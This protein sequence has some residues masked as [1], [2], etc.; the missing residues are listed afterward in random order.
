MIQ[1]TK[2][3]VGTVAVIIL[4]GFAGVGGAVYHESQVVSH[5]EQPVIVKTVVVVPTVEPTA[6]PSAT[7]KPVVRIG[8]PVS[9]TK[10]LT[11]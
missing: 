2:T 11:K 3:G 7:V 8:T 9:V 5:L 6:T 1:I 4:G 10:P